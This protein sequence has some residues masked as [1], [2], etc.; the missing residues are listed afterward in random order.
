MIGAS[1][2]GCRRPMSTPTEAPQGAAERRRAPAAPA[3]GP[4]ATERI[5]AAATD[6]LGLEELRPGQAE[7]AAAILAGRDT[8]A[9]V[10]TGTVLERL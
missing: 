8:L 1:V 10:P 9:V 7:A 4:P 5:R 3:D 6:L 2:D